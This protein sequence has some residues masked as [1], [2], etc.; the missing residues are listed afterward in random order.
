MARVKEKMSHP[1]KT[2]VN[3]AKLEKRCQL[4]AR[5][6]FAPAARASFSHCVPT[7]LT[8]TRTESFK[9]PYYPGLRKCTLSILLWSIGS[10]SIMS[11]QRLY[12]PNLKTSGL[13][14][15]H[16][17]TAKTSRRLPKL[18]KELVMST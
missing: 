5:K 2:P 9:S 12:Y 16:C 4:W 3:Q 6:T 13:L 8:V 17:S 1:I 18:L 10:L 7:A 11:E 15:H 14:Y